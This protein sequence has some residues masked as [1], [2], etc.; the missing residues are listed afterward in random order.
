[1]PLTN[2]IQPDASQQN[3][4]GKTRAILARRLAD[5]VCLPSS[6]ITPVERHMSG[7]LLVG[8]L[9][10]SP[11]D[12]RKRCARR[13]ASLIDAA[14]GLLRF[15][16]HDEI[17]VARQVL[18]DSEALS[19][20]LLVEAARTTTLDHRLIIAQRRGLNE[21]VCEALL[22]PGEP[23]VTA[24]VL[25]NRSAQ[26]SQNGLS[27]ALELSREYPTLCAILL[28]RDELRPAQGM[29]LFWWAGPKERAQ[30]L[31]RFAVGRD[32]MQDIAGDIFSMMAEEDW[33][34]LLVR[35]A[36]QF[37][38]RRQRNRA[39]IDKSPYS[40]L[41]NA[42]DT[43]LETGMDATLAEE[44]S[45]LSGIKPVT[46]ARILSDHGGEPIAVLCKATGLKRDYLLKLWRALKRPTGAPD[47]PDPALTRTI[48]CFDSLSSNKA[49]TVLR[50]WNWAFNA[51]THTTGLAE[52]SLAV[53]HEITT[54]N[55]AAAFV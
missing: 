52:A 3:N 29:T 55:S 49:Q 20:Y 23:E 21:L 19:D 10:Q 12:L 44:I 32:I 4:T 45:Y 2:A 37:I 17:E 35:K 6:R 8:I 26:L 40:S 7:D 5:I 42:V 30:V 43:A 13:V 38:E 54:P 47:T 48:Q 39:A 25:K 50:Y 36:M 24:R 16:I 53:D 14:P 51:E 11:L 31:N 27:R 33:Q 1:M 34:D 41:E 18:E 15:L 28:K 22:A 9:A 46:G